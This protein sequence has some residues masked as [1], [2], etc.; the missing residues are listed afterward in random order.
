MNGVV[1]EKFPDIATTLELTQVPS[2][3]GHICTLAVPENHQGCAACEVRCF[4]SP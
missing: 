2:D 3:Y 1:G 4:C